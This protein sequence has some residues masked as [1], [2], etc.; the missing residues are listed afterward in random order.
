MASSTRVSEA[1]SKGANPGATVA[2]DEHEVFFEEV[3]DYLE[4]TFPDI[5]PTLSRVDAILDVADEVGLRVGFAGSKAAE[6]FKRFHARVREILLE[7]NPI[8]SCL[9]GAFAECRERGYFAEQ[10][11]AC[12]NSCGFHTMDERYLA[13][14]RK[15]RREMKGC[16]F[17]HSADTDLMVGRG[18]CYL[19]VEDQWLRP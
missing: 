3:Q 9:D 10:D 1:P 2:D 17:Y 6:E 8:E 11:F 5:S 4:E 18:E 12:C 15:Q 16:V 13:L 14:P 7:R 19:A